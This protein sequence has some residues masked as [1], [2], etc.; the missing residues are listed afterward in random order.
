MLRASINRRLYELPEGGSILDALRA[1]GSHDVY[2][3]GGAA[4]SGGRDG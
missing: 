1:A 3:P 2:F 4:V